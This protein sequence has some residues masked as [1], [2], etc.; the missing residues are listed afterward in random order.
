MPVHRRRSSTCRG[1]GFKRYV[2]GLDS[3]CMADYLLHPSISRSRTE[4]VALRNDYHAVLIVRNIEGIAA[5]SPPQ[6]RYFTALF[7]QKDDFST[8]IGSETILDVVISVRR[9]NG[10]FFGLNVRSS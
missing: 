2:H 3:M 7:R 1:Q 8:V 5:I 9:V 4:E 10:R 6:R